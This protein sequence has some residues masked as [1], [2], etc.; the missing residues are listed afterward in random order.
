MRKIFGFLCVIIA[1]ICIFNYGKGDMSWSTKSYIESCS[2]MESKP[3]LPTRYDDD[4]NNKLDF[5][6]YVSGNS[7]SF[8]DN[9][10]GFFKFIGALFSYLWEWIKFVFSF[11]WWLLDCIRLLFGYGLTGTGVL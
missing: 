3:E 2:N 4:G 11:I 7:S 1:V 5:S 6:S 8:W 10:I 9:C